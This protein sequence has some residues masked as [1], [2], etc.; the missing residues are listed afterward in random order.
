MLF[1][2]DFSFSLNEFVLEGYGYNQ[3]LWIFLSLTMRK[4]SKTLR[5]WNMKDHKSVQITSLNYLA[6]EI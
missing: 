6:L 1:L 3:H 2:L 4:L 5:S